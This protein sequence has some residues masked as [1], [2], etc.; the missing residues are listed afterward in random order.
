MRYC[1]EAREEEV[2]CVLCHEVTREVV[3]ESTTNAG[4]AHLSVCGGREEEDKESQVNKS[5][6]WMR[7]RG[8]M[9]GGLRRGQFPCTRDPERGGA[10]AIES[11]SPYQ[12]G[13]CGG[14]GGH[15]VFVRKA[16]TGRGTWRVAVEIGQGMGLGL[17]RARRWSWANWLCMH[18]AKYTDSRP[19]ANEVG[20]NKTSK[21]PECRAAGRWFAGAGKGTQRASRHRYRRKG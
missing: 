1:V 16:W 19:A 5:R 11:G 3:Y 14:P 21:P 12:Q 10:V 17:V 18:A 8:Y 15:L 7:Y 2:Y 20:D 4:A 9:D 6:R 13:C